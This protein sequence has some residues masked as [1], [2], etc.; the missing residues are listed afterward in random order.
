MTARPVPAT[1][2]PATASVLV[3][4]DDD[5]LGD[6]PWEFLG[7]MVG[8]VEE[9][10]LLQLALAEQGDPECDGGPE[11]YVLPSPLAGRVALEAWYR[12]HDALRR[13]TPRWGYQLLAPDGRY[14]YLPLHVVTVEVAD[15]NVL[16]GALQALNRALLPAGDPGRDGELA[17]LL[18]EVADAFSGGLGGRRLTAKGLVGDFGRVLGVLTLAPDDDTRLLLDRLDGVDVDTIVLTP[19]DAAAYTRLAGRFTLLLADADP[20]A[21]FGYHGH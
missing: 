3:P 14:E 20:L 1:S 17:E 4:A 13:P 16:D 21:R 11:P 6:A 5:L 19:T 10:L 15:L 8:Q 7:G 12:V 9:P 2:T 18:A